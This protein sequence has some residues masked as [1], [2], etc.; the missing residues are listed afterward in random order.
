MNALTSA[1]L[2]E[3]TQQYRFRF[4]GE[5]G[6]FFFVIVKNVLLTLVTLGLYT[7]WAKTERRRYVW[8]STEIHSQRLSYTGTGLE[9]F[10]GYLKLAGVYVVVFIVPM[11]L[12]RIDK[13]LGVVAQLSVGL[14]V[15]FLLPFALWW[16]RAYLLSR[17]TWRGV[18]LRLVGGAKPFAQSFIGG[19][20]LSLLTLGLYTPYFTNNVRAAMTNA[21]YLGSQPFRYDGRGK[22]VFKIW[23]K[24]VIL[25]I[26]SLGIYWFWMQAHLQKYYFEHTSFDGARG[27]FTLRG[28]D[29][30]VIFMGQAFGTALTLG[31]AFPWIA[32]WSL[33]KIMNG[34]SFE[35]VIDFS[36]I[37]AATAQGGASGEV[38]A[39]A[40][41]VDLGF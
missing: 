19:A 13:V 8:S 23:I 1:Q 16:S 11:V 2:E 7:P 30:F 36:R 4:H 38:L 25:T 14:L 31:L 27:R 29:L 26:L 22:E 24:G 34:L 5:G 21:T 40:L 39:D 12:G 10:K 6:A 20:L 18:R 9:L 3:P 33:N 28:S 41:G 37:E 35:G 17:T 32:C 15:M